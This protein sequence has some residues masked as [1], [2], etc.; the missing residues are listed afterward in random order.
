MGIELSEYDEVFSR[1]GRRRGGEEGFKLDDDPA[2]RLIKLRDV[3]RTIAGHFH[4]DS[5]P[6]RNTII[7]WIK[8]GLLVGE[9]IGVGNNYYVE[10]Q[11]LTAFIDQR[12]QTEIA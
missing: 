2:P 10:E 9:Q 12:L 7:G 8:A 11:S 6:S 4:P 5:R 3:E 1:P